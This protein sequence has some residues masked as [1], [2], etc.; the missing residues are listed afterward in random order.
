[1]KIAEI[2]VQYPKVHELMKKQLEEMKDN[3]DQRNKVI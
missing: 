3:I 2:M 1:M